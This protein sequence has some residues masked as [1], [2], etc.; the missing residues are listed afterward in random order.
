ML[1]KYAAEIEQYVSSIVKERDDA[2]MPTRDQFT[3]LLA[4][5][6]AAR[7]VPG[8]PGRMDENGEYI[9]N[10]DE[11]KIVRDFMAKMYKIDS[12]DSLISYQKYQFRGSVEYE[13]F[14]TFWKEA[15]LFDINEL[16]PQGRAAFEHMINLAKAFYPMLEEKGLYA[17]DICEYIGVSRIARACGI[18]DGDEFNEIVD[19][20]VR[21]AQVFYH[22]FKE[23]ALSYLCGALYFPASNF[24]MDGLDQFF[25]IQKNVLK[26]LFDENGDWCY[27]KWYEPAEREWVA[28]YP[29]NIGCFVTKAALDKGIEYMYHDEPSPNHP[30]S[31]WRFFHGDETED[32]VN[33]IQNTQIVSLNTICNLCPTVLAFLE[34]PVKSAYGWNGKDWIKEKDVE[35]EG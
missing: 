20:F 26:Y 31:G 32:Y 29:G 25:N 21:K 15:P 16:E 33:D 13:Q 24:G 10:E 14:M 23:Y 1:E 3:R 30:D 17:W 4:S 9:C 35:P 5:P 27:Y 34:A 18:I 28:V 12:K 8:I 22:S 19:R 2:V 11:A 6:A 7:K